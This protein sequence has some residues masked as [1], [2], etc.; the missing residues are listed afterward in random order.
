[1]DTNTISD[2]RYA[3]FLFSFLLLLGSHFLDYHL[4]IFI[5]LALFLVK[6][7]SL[8][9]SKN[10]ILVAF[11]VLSMYVTWTF[12][13][14]RLVSDFTLALEVFSHG[15]FIFL[16][17]LL[18]L[19]IKIKH[20]GSTLVSDRNIFYALFLFVISYSFFVLWSYITITQDTSLSGVGMYVCF[21]NPYQRAHVNG[22]RLISTILTYYLTLMTFIL[23]FILF[24]FTKLKRKGF[25]GIELL[26][27]AA[28]AIFILYITALMGRRT[29]FALFALVFVLLF[30]LQFVRVKIDIKKML[31]YSLVV[32]AFL[33]SIYAFILEPKNPAKFEGFILTSDLMI[34]L[35]GAPEPSLLEKSMDFPIVKKLM[36]VGLHDKRFG[37]WSTAF[38]VILTYPYG[39]GNGV[40]IAPGIRLA[41][42]TW[43][44]IGKDFGIIPFVLFFIVTLLHLYYLVKIFFSNYVE[45]LLKYQLLMIAIGVFAIMMIEPV[46]TSD[47]TFFAYIFFYFGVV[48]NV[49]LQLKNKQ[50][51]SL[52][53]A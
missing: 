46:F 37:W 23:P 43:I 32:I 25:Y 24:Y 8:N 2:N 16:M 28:L 51:I 11:F 20:S 30:L 22:G 45:N 42:N 17:Y 29:V 13:D 50:E 26:L 39:G 21:P 27:L 7:S 19:S 14:K 36:A 9:Q 6:W 5:I 44:D 15:I 3:I 18:G 31:F 33:Y 10:I 49:Y 41:H 34:P 12:L 4:Y 53:K 1:L 40:Y 52:E 38:D 47:K 48:C 35:M